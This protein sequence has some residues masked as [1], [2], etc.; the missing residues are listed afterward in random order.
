MSAYNY[1]LGAA[2]S[3]VLMI[4]IIV[5]MTVMNRFGEEEGSVVT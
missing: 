5:S 2:I 4:L 1:N 3:F